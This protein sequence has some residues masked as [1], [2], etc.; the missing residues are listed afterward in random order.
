MGVSSARARPSP[1]SG[2]LSGRDRNVIDDMF[3]HHQFMGFC[4]VH[5]VPETSETILELA[6]IQQS[7]SNYIDWVIF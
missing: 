6:R 3:Q 7:L 2:D 1:S 4:S 5:L